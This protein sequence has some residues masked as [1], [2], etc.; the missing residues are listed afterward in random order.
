MNPTVFIV[1]DDEDVRHS[2]TVL[3]RARKLTA[4]S[5]S[6]PEKFHNFYRPEFPGCLVIDVQMP[7]Q[8]GLELYER[9]L[10]EG[11]RLPVIFITAHAKVSTAVAAMK[12]G[13]REVL[14]KPFDHQTLLERVERAL[15]LDGQ[16]RAREENFAALHSRISQ[17]TEREQETLQMIVA[18]GPNKHIAAQFGISQRAVEMRRAKIM[19]KLQVGS[20]GELLDVAV[21]FRV[22]SELR[23]AAAYDGLT[24]D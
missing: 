2:L 15:A 23:S 20:V 7:G 9:L 5:F 12:L 17:L 3:L 4:R 1:D 8:S 18:G 19:Q 22:L 10:R 16:W 14:E 24:G 11:K 13:A 21:T 6:T